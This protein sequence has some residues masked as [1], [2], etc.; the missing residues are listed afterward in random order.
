MHHKMSIKCNCCKPDRLVFNSLSV[1]EREI[2]TDLLVGDHLVTHSF[3]PVKNDPTIPSRLDM[4]RDP[5][6]SE[7]LHEPLRKRKE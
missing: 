2:S 6:E 4:I 7:M 5:M 3:L 1:G